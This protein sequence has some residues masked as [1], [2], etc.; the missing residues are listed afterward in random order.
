MKP[1]PANKAK[2]MKALSALM[3]ARASAGRA[4]KPKAKPLTRDQKVK[5]G[6]DALGDTPI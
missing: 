2:V 6:E 3:P 4:T 1:T 5:L